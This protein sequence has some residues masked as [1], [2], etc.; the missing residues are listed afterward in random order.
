MP[1]DP[2]PARESPLR[3][4]LETPAPSGCGVSGAR[5]P[6]VRLRR[7]VCPRGAP[8]QPSP[9][10]GPPPPRL[11]PPP[12]P[13]AAPYSLN[14]FAPHPH[15]RARRVT[16]TNSGTVLRGDVDMYSVYSYLGLLRLEVGTTS[17]STLA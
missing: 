1:P 4:P 16:K 8:G 14:P 17:S 3:Q 2:R 6:S 10:S 11:L 13:S 7:I 9:F 12:P 5:T 15:P